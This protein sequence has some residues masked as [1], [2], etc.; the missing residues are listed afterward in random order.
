MTTGV[1]LLAYGSPE[2]P[3]EVEPYF[4]HIRGG[5][6]PSPES[7]EHLRDRYRRVGGRTPLLRITREVR[8]ALE[9][10]LN[11]DAGP[12]AYRVY[13]GMKH[14]H[15]FTGDVM[16][17][18][19]SD[20]IRRVVAMALAPHYSRISIGGY[21]NGVDA[22]QEALGHPFELTFVDSWHLQPEFLAV[23]AGHVRTALAGFSRRDGDHVTAVFTAHSLPVRIR[24]WGDP[25]EAQ[26][27]ASSAAVAKAVGLADWRFAWQSAGSTGEPWLG[28]DI[29]DELDT[30]HAE[31][32]RQVLQVPIGFV[33]DHLEIL[34]DIDVEAADKAE[35]L[36][37][38]FARTALPNATPAFIEALAAVVIGAERTSEAA[39]ATPERG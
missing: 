37:I 1:L 27:L 30:L 13:V 2:N 28:P 22:A 4:T 32:V 20:G 29:L 19:A 23:I 38:E 5:R 24:E 7:V 15:P 8:G 14:W 26:L 34:Y 12:A 21:R 6:T 11:R 9:A 16:R 36:G 35:A 3:D 33:S 25:Y 39:V 18:M 10:H 17:T 31:G